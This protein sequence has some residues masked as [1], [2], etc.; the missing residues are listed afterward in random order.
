MQMDMVPGTTVDAV[1]GMLATMAPAYGATQ[2][3]SG[4]T[5]GQ[6]PNS[7]ALKSRGNSATPVL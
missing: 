1:V 2:R 4:P 5:I 3:G 7:F 6:K